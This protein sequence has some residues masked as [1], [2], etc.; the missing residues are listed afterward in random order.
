MIPS[1]T[2][3][4]LKIKG[5]WQDMRMNIFNKIVLL[6]IL[7]LIPIIMLYG[8]SYRVSMKVINDEIRSNNLDQLDF[9]LK[10]ME[11]Q[12]N[13]LV[14]YALALNEDPDINDYKNLDEYTKYYDVIELMLRI[15]QKI[16]LQSSL[17]SWSNEIIVYS[18]AAKEGVGL[19]GIIPFDETIFKGGAAR[20]WSYRAT[21]AERRFVRHIVRPGIAIEVSF[22]TSNIQGFLDNYREGS[23]QGPFMYMRGMEPIVRKASDGILVRHIIEDTDGSLMGGRGSL[24]LE[25]NGEQYMVSY[26]QSKA[27]GWTLI[28]YVPMNE[29]VAPIVKSRNLFFSSVALL[30]MMSVLASI[31]LYRNVHIPIY[32]LIKSLRSVEQGDYSTRV[33]LNKNNEFGYLFV[34][35][36]QMVRQIQE[37]IEKVLVE[38]IR[39]REATL[40]HLQSQIKP[41]FLYNS[42]FYIKNMAKLGDVDSIEGMAQHLGEYYRYNTRTEKNADTLENELS[43]I[44]NY[45]EIY[46][47][48]M[49]RITY[50]ISVE[51]SMKRLQIPKLIIQPIVENAV[52]HGIEPKSGDG[53]IS[54]KGE[55]L[56]GYCLIVIEDNG[57]GISEGRLEQ[58]KREMA[59]PMD[60]QTGCGIWNVHQRLVLYF[61]GG[62]GLRIERGAGEGTRV[63][64]RWQAGGGKL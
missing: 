63:E 41:H 48:R 53:H 52:L 4:C 64:I 42:L 18:A 28:D 7:L 58:L 19:K 2:L 57:I 8:Y 50:S 6:V 38:E 59:I 15:D 20:N 60:E 17:S 45:L 56:D 33:V 12:L 10:Q 24:V 61:G 30:L 35:Y 44:V 22:P 62:S 27:L 29:L 36:N 37:L 13:E 5:E 46:A 25:I 39:S 16:L 14:I 1:L 40:K 3:F 43:M 11:A 32:R 49:E 23:E 51:E 9:M 34:R 21:E 26:I 47:L 55:L 54:I 31:L